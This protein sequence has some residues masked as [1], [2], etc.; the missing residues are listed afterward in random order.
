VYVAI[1]RAA[2]L[3]VAIPTIARYTFGSQISRNSSL[4]RTTYATCAAVVTDS[5]CH[6][7]LSWTIATPAVTS[8]IACACAFIAC[9]F[10][11]LRL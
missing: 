5:T 1:E 6:R 7:H 9:A 3:L 2:S 4:N 11:S 10:R 8:F